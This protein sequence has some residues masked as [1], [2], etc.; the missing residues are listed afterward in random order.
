MLNPVRGLTA[1]VAMIL[2][3]LIFA[4]FAGEALDQE[5]SSSVGGALNTGKKAAELVLAHQ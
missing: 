2:A 3:G 5:E 4:F 1:F